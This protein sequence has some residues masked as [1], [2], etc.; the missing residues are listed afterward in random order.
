MD[1]PLTK[2]MSAPTASRYESAMKFPTEKAA[3]A[4]LRGY[5]K[6]A[7]DCPGGGSGGGGGGG[8]GG[9]KCDI[10]MKKI[11]FKLGDERW[12]YQYKMKCTKAGQTTRSVFNSLFA[13]KGKF[14]VYANIMSKD[15]SAPSIPRR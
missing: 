10:D 15:A 5:G 8:T 6:S 3:I 13:R 2:P 14:I 11:A 1:P 12:G 9:M 7:K 4:Y